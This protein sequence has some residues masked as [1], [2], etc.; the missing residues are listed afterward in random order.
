LQITVTVLSGSI[1]TN[2]VVKSSGL[3]STPSTVRPELLA[4]EAGM[5]NPRVNP[6]P[7]IVVNRKKSRREIPRRASSGQAASESSILRRYMTAS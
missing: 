1:R 4:A 2:G 5:A 6:E 7:A 3:P